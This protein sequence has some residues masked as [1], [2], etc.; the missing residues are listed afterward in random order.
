MPNQEHEQTLIENGAETIREAHERSP[1]IGE[2]PRRSPERYNENE[3]HQTAEMARHEAIKEALFSKE[4]GKERRSHQADRHNAAHHIVTKNDR[5]VSF[6]QTMTDVRKHLPRSTRAFSK[7]IHIPD[8]ERASDM[9]G[10]TI[11]RPHAILA[12]GVT[13][14]IVVLGL[15]LY[16]KY[17]GFA[18]R[19]SETIV[20]FA[21]GWLL[22]ILF[23]F[24][25]ALF[26]R[27]R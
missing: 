15:Y 25:K 3:A 27:R 18:L 22:G 24:L 10:E 16:A 8:V 13:G 17:A 1:E 20:A 5:E 9:L 4:Q 19:G 11:A 26:T 23:D 14:F 21:L 12:G 7:F 6:D 2:G